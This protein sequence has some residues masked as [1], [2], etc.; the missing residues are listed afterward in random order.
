MPMTKEEEMQFYLS[1]VKA[2]KKNNEKK[3]ENQEEVDN[4]RSDHIYYNN[5]NSLFDETSPE[6]IVDRILPSFKSAI[7]NKKG[8]FPDPSH[9]V[10]V[11]NKI[12]QMVKKY[13]NEHGFS[14]DDVSLLKHNI[15]E[16][17][18]TDRS[19][20]SFASKSFQI[21]KSNLLSLSG[22]GCLEGKKGW[23]DSY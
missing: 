16:F 7:M 20:I 5:W 6:R 22:H 1:D 13:S 2:Y 12:E 15:S 21:E 14:A 4:F 17:T 3:P 10:I 23:T 18:E 8:I 19:R 11:K 9:Y